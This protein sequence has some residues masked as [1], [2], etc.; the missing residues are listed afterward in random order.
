[1]ITG[2]KNQGSLY[3]QQ[4]YI[5]NLHECQLWNVVRRQVARV[6]K[7]EGEVSHFKVEVLEDGIDDL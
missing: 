7:L 5:Q 2:T 1:M 3:S 4:T 6:R